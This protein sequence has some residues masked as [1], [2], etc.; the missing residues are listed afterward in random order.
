MFKNYCKRNGDYVM[1]SLR[2]DLEYME[3][4]GYKIRK[5]HNRTKNHP[6]YIIWNKVKKYL[7]IDFEIYMNSS[8]WNFTIIDGYYISLYWD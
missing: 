4:K 7:R 5:M 6:C 2:N 8:M 3:H 1:A